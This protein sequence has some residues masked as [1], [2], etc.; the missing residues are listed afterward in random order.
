MRL[1]LCFLLAILAR[2]A[3]PLASDALIVADEFPAMAT[4]AAALESA[5]V[6]RPLRCRIVSQDDLPDRLDS[7]RVVFVYIHGDLKPGPERAFI[8]YAEGG[9]RL[10]LLH[11]SISSGKRKNRDWFPFLGIELPLGEVEAGGYKWIEPAPLQVLQLAGH[12]ITTNQ[13]VWP[14]RAPA[15]DALPAAAGLVPAVTLPHSEVY[16]NHRL[17]GERTVLLGL[18]HVDPATGQVWTQPTAGWL[19]RAGQGWL[20]YFMPGHTKQDFESPVYGQVLINTV[21]WT[22]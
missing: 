16:L 2:P 8:D 15:G 22:P 10:V 3:V 13:V 18:R 20:F 4:L 1:L 14:E 9:G 5:E 11:H 12:F 17:V 21:A 19:R 7:F 6:L